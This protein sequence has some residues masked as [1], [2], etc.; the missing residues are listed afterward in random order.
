MANVAVTNVPVRNVIVFLGDGM[1][2]S[3]VTAARIFDGQSRGAPG[4]ENLLSFERFPRTAMIKTYNS[5]QQVSD[6][7]GTAT[8]IHS[9]VKTRAGVIGIGPEAERGDCAA[10]SVNELETIGDLAKDRGIAVGIVTTSRVT[11]ATP[12]T[13]YSHSPDRD[14]ESDRYLSDEQIA[15]GCGDIAR[16]LVELPDTRGPDIVLGGGRREFVGGDAGGQR[17]QADADL[18]ESWLAAGS[19]RVVVESAESLRSL[20]DDQRVLGVFSSSHMTYVAERTEDTSEPTIQEMT[21][22]AIRY[23]EQQTNGYYLLVE[24]ARIDH[25]HH[26]GKP[27]YALLETQAFAEAVAVALELVDLSET[28]VLVTADHSHV[29]TLAGYPTRGNPILGLVVENDDRGNPQAEPALAADGQPFTSVGY[30]NGPGALSGAPRPAPG[31]AIDAIAQALVPMARPDIDG[32]I[33]DSESHSGEDVVLYA[34]GPGSECVGGVLEQNRIFDL[35]AAA[36]GW[37][38]RICTPPVW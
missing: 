36:Y 5:N 28:L 29:F 1:G 11:H 23:L 25:G 20:P 24:G 34:T 8:A 2:V 30:A 26:D 13:L 12:A 16:Q 18:L 15:A 9:G 31:T 33:S 21:A 38:D 17:R 22:A 32:S 3:T 6:S 37:A 19:N 4:E 10:A 7:A 35:I 14:W 27:G